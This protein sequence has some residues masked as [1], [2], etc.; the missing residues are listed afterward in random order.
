MTIK[1]IG[2]DLAKNVF[3]VHNVDERG[4][5]VSVSEFFGLISYSSRASSCLPLPRLAGGHDNF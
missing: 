2:I 3:Q 5:V 4:H 1:T